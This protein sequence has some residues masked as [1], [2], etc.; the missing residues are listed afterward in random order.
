MSTRQTVASVPALLQ[1][2]DHAANS[3]IDPAAITL[4]SERRVW[5]RCSAGHGWQ[6]RVDS[7]GGLRRPGCPFCVGRRASP[8][9]NLAV[10]HPE[11]AALW[12]AER[13]GDLDPH[14]V[15]AGAKRRVWWR[16]EQGHEWQSTVVV[17]SRF[18]QCPECAGWVLAPETSL[19]ARAPEL[20]AQWHP[21]AN[22][23]LRPT[24][25]SPRSLRK[26]FWL[27][28]AG[29]HTWAA[30]VRQRLIK[31]T[32]CPECAYSFPARARAPL[33]QTHPQL[34]AQWHPSRN[35][36]AHPVHVT[37]GSGRRVWWRCEQGHEWQAKI[38]SRSHGTGCPV[39]SGWRYNEYNTLALKRPELAIE[40]H[41]TANGDLTPDGVAPGSPRYAW[42][43]CRTCGHAWRARINARSTGSGCP[44][45]AADKARGRPPSRST[46]QER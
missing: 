9:N 39:C 43:Q 38:N 2:W 17:R 27:C 20:A 8:E 26:V 16:C 45:C 10:T 6:A 22:G 24:Q 31:R 19:A 37:Y 18:P 30:Q 11:V 46:S 3:E 44:V 12:H 14:D 7:R 28:P 13:N 36:A 25:V 21:T 29:G 23:D 1:E 35:G 42:W 41:P 32:G 4:G 40:W 34:A 33:T 5:W 15:V